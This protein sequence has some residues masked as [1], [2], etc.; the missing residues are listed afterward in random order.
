[1]KLTLEPTLPETVHEYPT[2]SVSRPTDDA[3][4]VTM[5]DMWVSAMEAFGY[6]RESIADAIQDWHEAD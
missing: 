5:L 3:D 4:V 1:M 6:H 2:I